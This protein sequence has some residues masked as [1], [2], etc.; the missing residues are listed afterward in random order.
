[1]FVPKMANAEKYV[2]MPTDTGLRIRKPRGM[3]VIVK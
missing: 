1:M 3:T 2:L